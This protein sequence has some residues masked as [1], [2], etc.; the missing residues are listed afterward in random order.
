[1]HVL[2]IF[3]LTSFTLLAL[4]ISNSP[5]SESRKGAVA[6]DIV[7]TGDI[8]SY[9]LPD[10]NNRGGMSRIASVIKQIKKKNQHALVFDLG[11]LVEGTLFFQAYY[12]KAEFDILKKLPYDAIVPG[13]H[14]FTAGPRV[15]AEAIQ[16][17]RGSN[18][19]IL[20]ANLQQE[21]IESFDS[22]NPAVSLKNRIYPSV[23]RNIQGVR[24]GILGLTT[25]DTNIM[26]QPSPLI[27]F[28]PLKDRAT[29]KEI[30]N[31]IK[32][33]T[34]I[35][36]VL[37]H[38]GS[39]KD[40][41]LASLF[42]GIDLILG[43]HSHLP[44][45]K[46]EIVFSPDADR[47]LKLGNRGGVLI[48]N[49]GPFGKHVVHMT[50]IYSKD[51]ERIIDWQYDLV[52]IDES[53]REDPEIRVLVEDYAKRV[54]PEA[55][56]LSDDSKI[57]IPVNLKAE[58]EDTQIINN[59]LGCIVADAYLHYARSLF[60][61]EAPH[62]VNNTKTPF[63]T[64]GLEAGTI[65]SSISRGKSKRSWIFNA[66]PLG[67]PGTNEGL[68]SDRTLPCQSDRNSGRFLPDSHS[69]YGS[70][71][72]SVDV[73][74]YSLLVAMNFG[75]N[76]GK[77]GGFPR[78]S[79]NVRLTVNLKTPSKNKIIPD[80]I[81]MMP[82]TPQDIDGDGELGVE[83]ILDYRV[84][85]RKKHGRKFLKPYIPAVISSIQRNSERFRNSKPMLEREPYNLSRKEALKAEKIFRIITSEVLLAG[86]LRYMDH[87]R[88][89]K[90][91]YSNLKVLP[92]TQ[93]EVLYDYLQKGDY[94]ESIKGCPNRVK[95]FTPVRPLIN[96]LFSPFPNPARAGGEVILSVAVN[97]QNREKN[98]ESVMVDLSAIGKGILD[99]K[100]SLRGEVGSNGN[101]YFAES[102]IPAT[103][104]P[105]LYPLPVIVKNRESENNVTHG[106]LML[107]IN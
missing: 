1:M 88:E 92:V 86:I 100:S 35:I 84:L 42:D 49:G 78:L 28:D 10:A 73:D 50:L 90:F 37:S 59:D 63:F 57:D 76:L 16:G 15:Y 21:S 95:L 64:I 68:F 104:K 2:R 54:L 11:D 6:I 3:L 58:K 70:R 13:N 96:G 97:D 20:C 89:F 91:Q 32:R 43:A 85:G 55:G 69:I 5:C 98:I 52:P 65:V 25:P 12:G 66:V 44:F 72:V 14:E 51:E 7:T 39:E 75:F 23:I 53:I 33:K 107:M 103:T 61:D 9:L 26:E 102:R 82:D 77:E 56:H 4:A 62:L 29:L 93:F 22:K 40:R 41:E 67:L 81:M 8:H 79:S 106:T 74:L 34:D 19:T 99:M 80:L 46:P 36:V 94:L 45:F 87:D 31:G 105:G 48:S 47:G 83:R 101:F 18:I 27:F 30:I 24:I 60:K 38:L 71:L 17:L